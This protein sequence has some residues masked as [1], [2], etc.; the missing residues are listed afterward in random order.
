MFTA[1][2]VQIYFTVPETHKKM[3]ENNYYNGIISKFIVIWYT[4]LDFLEVLEKIRSA[5]IYNN[6]N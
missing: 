6:K 1:K 3:T 4:A 5:H 2:I